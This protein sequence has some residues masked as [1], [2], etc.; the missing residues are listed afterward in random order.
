[1]QKAINSYLKLLRL[2]KKFKKFI[3]Y[4]QLHPFKNTFLAISDSLNETGIDVTVL[5]IP[6]FQIK[7]L[8]NFF[9]AQLNIQND[10]YLIKVISEDCYLIDGFDKT[11]N[12]LELEKIW[13][14][15]V[16]IIEKNENIFSKV[17]EYFFYLLLGGF[18]LFFV[19]PSSSNFLITTIT[20]FGLL[21]SI[22]VLKIFYYKRNFKFCSNLSFLSCDK[23]IGSNLKLFN[24][25]I[26]FADLPIIYFVFSYLYLISERSIGIIVLFSLFSIP[27]IIYSIYI[28]FIKKAWCILCLI[29]SGLIIGEIFCL[30]YLKNIYYIDFFYGLS[31]LIFIFICWQLIKN[32][33][34]LENIK[35]TK[36][37]I[38]LKWLKKEEEL[39]YSLSQQI[40]IEDFNLLEKISIKKENYLNTVSLFIDLNCKNCKDTLRK[41]YFNEQTNIDLYFNLLKPCDFSYNVIDTLFQIY[42]SNN[43]FFNAAFEDFLF[44]K[45]SLKQWC[46]KWG[47]KTYSG[48][49]IKIVDLHSNWCNNYSLDYIP[50]IIY[51]GH[52]ANDIYEIEDIV[53]FY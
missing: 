36:D 12:S 42:H 9:L 51:N 22:L 17:S 25:V 28:Q 53:S 35:A 27:L 39:F 40:N 48:Q 47:K 3:Y 29:V 10:F 31:L 16:L 49:V 20:L 11:F 45:Q 21:V 13:S 52:I 8:P 18:L 15:N 5:K 2:E 1:M 37:S 24:S 34:L 41:L 7:K 26:N 14:G 23:I 44:E 46:L 38:V 50:I 4:H 30:K 33:I 19:F 6:F 43:I 32:K